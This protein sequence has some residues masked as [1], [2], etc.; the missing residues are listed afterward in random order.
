MTDSPTSEG[1]Q[2]ERD[3]LYLHP[4]DNSSFTLVSLPLNGANFFTWS[5]A[6]YVALGCMMKLA[7]IDGT[8]PQ[9]P[10]GSALFEQWRRADLM[11]TSWLWNSIAKDIVE[12][13]MYVSSSRELWLEIQARYGRSSGPMIYQLQREIS[14]ISQGD[15]TLTSYLTKVKKLWNEL[16]CLAPSLKCTCGACTCGINKAIGEMYTALQLMQFLMGLHESFDKEKSQLLKMDPLPDLEK[17]F[18]ILFAVQQQRSIQTHVV[19][20]NATAAYQVSFKQ[21]RGPPQKQT[22]RRRMLQDKRCMIFTHCHKQGHLRETCF[23]LH[24]T[25]EWY[26]AL[27]DKKKESKDSYRFAGNLSTKEARNMDITAAKMD[28]KANIADLVTE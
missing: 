3:V 6:V 5:R 26:K 25:P 1:D 21:N 7:F 23:Q 8:F 18:L 20:N 17:A 16:F 24:G 4:F 14:L 28:T 2:C 9:P 11:V 22:Q 15:M 12:G 10:P 13:F 27:N 19:E